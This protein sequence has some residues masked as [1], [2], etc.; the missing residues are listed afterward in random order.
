[1]K[2]KRNQSTMVNMLGIGAAV[3]VLVF[4]ASVILV[5]LANGHL[6]D[7]YEDL[8]DL[9]MDAEKLGTASKYLTQEARAYAFSRA[10]AS[11]GYEECFTSGIEAAL[12][13]TWAISS[14]VSSMLSGDVGS[15]TLSIKL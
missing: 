12:G 1:M 5:T 14:S 10:A 3:L 2:Y 15:P 7:A 9:T 11:T 8:Y 6:N 4:V 13:M